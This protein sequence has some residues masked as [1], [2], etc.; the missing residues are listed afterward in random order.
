[1]MADDEDFDERLDNAIKIA[2]GYSGFTKFAASY[3]PLFKRLWREQD[4]QE[5]GHISAAQAELIARAMVQ[6]GWADWAPTERDHTLWAELERV[7]G[8]ITI[9]QFAEMSENKSFEV[10]STQEAAQ[11]DVAAP[12]K[13]E[14]AA[15]VGQA[16]ANRMDSFVLPDEK[17]LL[18]RDLRSIARTA[19]ENRQCSMR[20]QARA[21]TAPKAR[22][23]RSSTISVCVDHARRSNSAAAAAARSFNRSTQF[24]TT[25]KEC[26]AFEAGTCCDG[27]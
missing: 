10:P 16:H 21:D 26:D 22:C 20:T 23:V 25:Q 1:M 19:K 24:T 4:P 17:R 8:H 15:A 13:R 18:R 12:S 2:E 14:S 7:W 3:P 5:V 11:A 9:E 6:A 27:V